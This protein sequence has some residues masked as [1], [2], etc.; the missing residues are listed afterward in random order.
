MNPKNRR[1]FREGKEGSEWWRRGRNYFNVFNAESWKV[2]RN[3]EDEL[4]FERVLNEVRA[5][6][7]KES[8][9]SFERGYISN[10]DLWRRLPLM[11]MAGVVGCGF[12]GRW[13]FSEAQRRSA[14]N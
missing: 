6:R 11:T 4:K 7:M 13:V 8:Y 10:A 2:R 14:W 3:T 5:G 12:V 1:A 9:D